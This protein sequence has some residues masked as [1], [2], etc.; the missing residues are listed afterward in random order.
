MSANV[1]SLSNK[2]DELEFTINQ[3]DIDIAFICETEPKNFNPSLPPVSYIF[4]SYETI[5]NKD[6]RGVM[7][8]HKEHLEV[9]LIDDINK[10]FS[11][12]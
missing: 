6:G 10:I 5:H 4:N 7:I 12:S 11:P 3:K 2:K 1:D 8:I 9:S